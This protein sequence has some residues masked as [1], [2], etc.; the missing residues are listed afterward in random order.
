MG[1][2]HTTTRATTGSDSGNFSEAEQVG[3]L[4][5]SPYPTP[6]APTRSHRDLAHDRT[7]ERASKP[8]HPNGTRGAP[9]S[10]PRQI[11]IQPTTQTR[12][13]PGRHPRAPNSSRLLDVQ[14]PQSSWPQDS[15]DSRPS[16]EIAPS[17]LASPAHELSL[18]EPSQDKIS[19]TRLITISKNTRPWLPYPDRS[20]WTSRLTTSLSPITSFKPGHFG[21]GS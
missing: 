2:H 8:S 12:P 4:A 18:H 9:P 6:R 19:D 16:L 13:Q 10:L 11:L 15:Q 5:G 21:C 14:S 3:L 1:R 17:R 20:P 7:P